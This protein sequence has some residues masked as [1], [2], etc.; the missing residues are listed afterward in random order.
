MVP[1]FMVFN[2]SSSIEQNHKSVDSVKKGHAGAGIAI[3]IEGATQQLFGRHID[4]KETLYSQI[5]RHSIDTLKSPAMR[6]EVTK[7]EWALI[8]KL[9]TVQFIIL[10]LLLIQRSLGFK[11]VTGELKN[12]CHFVNCTKHVNTFHGSSVISFQD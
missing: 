4:E 12:L 1:S 7:D 10:K 11:F 5:S 9:K 2:H 8:V 3:K 6:D